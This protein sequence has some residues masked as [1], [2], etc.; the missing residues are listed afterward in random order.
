MRQRDSYLPFFYLPFRKI[1]TSV[2]NRAYNGGGDRL[3]PAG[4]VRASREII[5][6]A[7]WRQQPAQCPGLSTNSDLRSSPF[8]C[9]VRA[10]AETH[11]ESD[12]LD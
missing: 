8:P 11:G 3:P 9:A 5:T 10:R 2:N 1:P 7:R 4:A 12:A 6:A